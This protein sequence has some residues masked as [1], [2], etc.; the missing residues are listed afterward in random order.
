MELIFCENGV[1]TQKQSTNPVVINLLRTSVILENTFLNFFER[2][3][4]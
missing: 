3:D 2:S 4:H 1:I